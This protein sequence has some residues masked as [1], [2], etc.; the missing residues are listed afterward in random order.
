[1]QTKLTL[2]LN[3]RFIK[4]AKYYAKCHHQSLSQLVAHY[5]SLLPSSTKQEKMEANTP[6]VQSLRGCLRHAKVST[7]DYSQYLETKYL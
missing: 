5:F 4:Q 6:I 2:R 7:K 3:E 1:M